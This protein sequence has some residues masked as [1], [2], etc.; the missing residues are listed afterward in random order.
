MLMRYGLLIIALFLIQ[1]IFAQQ[2]E[3]FKLG[4]SMQNWATYT[5]GQS[6]WKEDKLVPVDDRLNFQVRRTNLVVAG[7]FAPKLSYK[8]NVAMDFIGRDI[9]SATQGGAN[10]GPSP[11]LRVWNVLAQ[12]QISDDE[13]AFLNIGYLTPQI[14]RESNNG[15]FVTS[16][17]EK[18][19]SQNYLRRTLVGTGPGRAVGLNLGGLLLQDR[20][21]LNFKYD[22]GLYS[23]QNS[24]VV[25][26]SAGSKQTPLLTA[27]GV[28]M[29]G[30]AEA[31][32]Y[33][34]GNKPNYFGKR[35]GLSL[36]ASAY[37][38]GE[39][40]LG[41]V[42]TGVGLDYLFNWGQMNID[43]DHTWMQ[44]SV[45]SENLVSNTGYARISYNIDLANGKIIEPAIS[46][47]YFNGQMEVDKQLIMSS[48]GM[49]SGTDMI[50]ETGINY[51]YSDKIKINLFYTL[52]QGDAG[53]L[54]P[55]MIV[56][57]YYNQ[58]GQAA[59][60]RGNMLSLGLYFR[61]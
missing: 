36:G 40:D 57:N 17:F 26:N 38:R 41:E 32:S 39:N 52:N 55:T 1:P 45:G 54:S 42:R 49:F 37:Y 61:V 24:V 48:L 33:G 15:A 43:G 10:N 2:N 23:P 51:H 56:N 60:T 34:L 3:K 46:L 12:W 28:I 29:I 50:L 4:F 25:G 14:G 7:K 27:R 18:P 35:K 6:T 22:I 31:S 47:S 44:S 30:D 5:M 21:K 13:S 53:E 20:E 19:W 59:I 58:S 16:S 8:A 11:A 9:Y